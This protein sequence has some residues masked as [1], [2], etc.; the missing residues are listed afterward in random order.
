MGPGFIG[1]W[2]VELWLA[3]AAN[4]QRASDLGQSELGAVCAVIY[5]IGG[6][7]LCMISAC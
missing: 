3:G 6:S 7:C 1:K 5:M 2:R 4:G